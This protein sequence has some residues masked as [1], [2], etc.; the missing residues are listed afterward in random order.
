MKFLKSKILTRVHFSVI[1]V[2]F[3]TPAYTQTAERT[4]EA[5]FDTAYNFQFFPS[6]NNQGLKVL[7]DEGHN[8]I[9]S[10]PYGRETAREMLR[11]MSADGFEID[12][13]K[14]VLDSSTI[15]TINPDLLIIHGIPND[16]I[17]LDSGETKE[18]FYKSPVMDKEVDG[19]INYIYGGGSL[20][21]F[22]SHHPGGSGAGPI[23]EALNVKFRDGYASHP[24]SPGYNNGICS[25]FIMTPE[26]NMINTR[27]P[28]FQD[29]DHGLVPDT[30]KFL[31]GAALFRNSED[32]ILSFPNNTANFSRS[33][34]GL[35]IK[36]TSDFYSGMIGFEYGSGRVIISTDQGVFR[37][38]DLLIDG[39]KIHVTIHD[40]ECDNAELLLDCIRWLG[41]A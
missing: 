31:C 25:H 36:E 37:S 35:N 1:L 41:K 26:N 17:F 16:K 15:A 2:F 21:L 28:I 20:F 30:V 18:V 40:P 27:H 22:L 23:L 34:A 13:T 14:E 10:K 4:V 5:E 29:I 38:L 32:A 8:T 39:I 11:I 3:S 9:Y 24:K 7:I 19:I 33:S 12:F 6:I